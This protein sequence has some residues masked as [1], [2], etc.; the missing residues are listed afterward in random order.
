[1]GG[2]QLTTTNFGARALNGYLAA[3]YYDSRSTTF[4]QIWH[5]AACFSRTLHVALCS[6]SLPILCL[7]VFVFTANGVVQSFYLSAFY[8]LSN[9]V[10][11]CER[12]GC[13]V[14]L[15]TRF[16]WLACFSITC[17]IPI[18]TK[19]EACVCVCILSL[20]VIPRLSIYLSLSVCVAEIE[21]CMLSNRVCLIVKSRGKW[22]T[23]WLV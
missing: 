10:C 21:A 12:E 3:G 16:A 20:S 14:L 15:F 19:T 6:L 5:R 23:V 13:A 4:A 7:G 1:M 8:N 18:C 22:V 17:M 11:V 9:C 2:C